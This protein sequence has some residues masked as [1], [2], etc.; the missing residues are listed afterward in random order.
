[1][2][3]KNT[4]CWTEPPQSG[5]LFPMQ[6]SAFVCPDTAY[7]YRTFM[8]TIILLI[9]PISFEPC[10][11]IVIAKPLLVL[12]ITI[13]NIKSHPSQR[14]V[15]SQTEKNLRHESAPATLTVKNNDRTC[16]T[17]TLLTWINALRRTVLWKIKLKP[18][19]W[20]ADRHYHVHTCSYYLLFSA[21]R[22]TS[23]QWLYTRDWETTVVLHLTCP[24]LSLLGQLLNTALLHSQ[25]NKIQ[26]PL[27][28]LSSMFYSE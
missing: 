24:F 1:M 23:T 17:H 5:N 18:G 21:A 19:S 16:P 12:A 11:L 28:D 13:R 25:L 10:H 8:R 7:L 15:L 2:Y 6:C 22:I 26:Q 20:K 14:T 3:I 4:D 27:C 9:K